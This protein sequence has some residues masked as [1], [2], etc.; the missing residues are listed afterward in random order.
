MSMSKVVARA[1]VDPAYKAKLLSDP[2]SA[3]AEAGVQV[4]PGSEVKVVEDTADTRHLVLPRSP[5][6]AAE[7]SE[8]E[9]EKVAAAGAMCGGWD[10]PSGG[11]EPPE[12]RTR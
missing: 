12:L 3:L 7:L 1:W 2:H 6:E 8:Q 10:G 4:P 11:V 9:L 5:P